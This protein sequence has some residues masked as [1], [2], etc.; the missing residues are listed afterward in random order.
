MGNTFISEI[1]KYTKMYL[2]EDSLSECRSI[3]KAIECL[4]DLFIKWENKINEEHSK[5]FVTNDFENQLGSFAIN[6]A[7][8]IAENQEEIRKV[9]KE[10][11]EKLFCHRHLGYGFYKSYEKTNLFFA[12]DIEVTKIL[13]HSLADYFNQFFWE[14]DNKVLAIR[15]ICKYYPES[16]HVKVETKQVVMSALFKHVK[17]AGMPGDVGYS[18]AGITEIQRWFKKLPT[19]IIEGILKQYT[20]FDIRNNKVCRNQIYTIIS[21]SKLSEVNKYIYKFFFIDSVLLADALTRILHRVYINENE[22]INDLTWDRADCADNK[23]LV[24]NNI[25]KKLESYW[26]NNNYKHRRFNIGDERIAEIKLVHNKGKIILTNIGLKSIEIS[27]DYEDYILSKYNSEEFNKQLKVIFKQNY[28]NNKFLFSHIWISN[29]HGINNQQLSLDHSFQIQTNNNSLKITKSD[30][31]KKLLKGFW[32]ESIYSMSA[33][34]GKNGTGKT[35]VIDFLRDEFFKL[36][37]LIDQ[38]HLTITNGVIQQDENFPLE[39]ILGSRYLIVFGIESKSYFITNLENIEYNKD[40]IMPYKA[41]SY[42]TES[43]NS[44]IIYFS[45]AINSD[46]KETFQLENNSTSIRDKTGGLNELLRVINH[47]R[48]IDFSENRSFQESHYEYLQYLNM[49]KNQYEN[50][51]EEKEVEESWLFKNKEFWY[52]AAFLDA[53][54]DKDFNKWL[55]EDFKKSSL[56][57]KRLNEEIEV[58]SKNTDIMESIAGDFNNIIKVDPKYLRQLM[59]R[60]KYFSAG[61]YAKFAF[62]SK[63]YWCINGYEKYHKKIEDRVGSNLFDEQD[64]IISNSTAVIFI[65]EGELYYH[66]EWQRLYIS[67]LV[68]LVSD[69]AQSKNIILQIIITSNS[70]FIISDMPSADIMFLPEGLSENQVLTFGSNIHTM[71][72]NGFFMKSTIGEFARDKIVSIFN[73]LKEIKNDSKNR[74]YSNEMDRLKLEIDIIGDELIKS[75]LQK[76]YY[77][78]FPKEISSDLVVYQNELAELREKGTESLKID[79]ESVYKLKSMLKDFLST[80]EEMEGKK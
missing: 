45:T 31:Y 29:Y 71:L 69:Y 56:K 18:F 7:V 63:L 58:D 54:T 5:P 51:V 75:R 70:P 52:Q 12:K 14:F 65:D 23:I 4:N 48:Y 77:E 22:E 16:A 21:S 28:K 47:K 76:L 43:E 46:V 59:L 50:V 25:N 6:C 64:V 74:D 36:L 15:M 13:Y 55:G 33:I 62:L 42:K 30:K 20:I 60:F 9:P 19:Q 72:R 44:K 38:R 61:Q 32:G 17:F 24:W 57:C 79:N 10:K 53:F 37:Y 1:R 73:K 49:K 39:S 27:F 80:L 34:V 2:Q 3:E 41:K 26:Y 40:D 78:C 68:N 8:Q 67:T 35:S 11:L 66:P